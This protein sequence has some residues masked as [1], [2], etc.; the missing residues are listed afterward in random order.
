MHTTCKEC[1]C[2]SEASGNKR[3]V[4]INSEIFTLCPS[5][6]ST[7]TPFALS[8]RHTWTYQAATAESDIGPSNLII[9]TDLFK[10]FSSP[11]TWAPSMLWLNTKLSACKA[12]TLP[13]N[14]GCSQ[15]AY[16]A[17]FLPSIVSLAYSSSALCFQQ[18]PARCPNEMF[19]S[20]NPS[21]LLF[22]SI[23]YSEVDCIWIW[24]LHLT[25][26]D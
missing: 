19:I 5:A 15:W 6:D 23:W 7:L 17:D 26:L 11:A 2:V 14:N 1:P 4:E 22:C 8:W 3:E 20:K 10:V 24:R 18:Q 21:L 9:Y 25:F 12:C 16:E 13:L